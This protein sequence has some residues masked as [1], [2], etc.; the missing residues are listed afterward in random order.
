VL[1]AV[2]ILKDPKGRLIYLYSDTHIKMYCENVQ[3]FKTM[4]NTIK[5]MQKRFHFLVEAP[6]PVYDNIDDNPLSVIM[7]IHAY[8]NKNKFP[9]V[10][11]ENVELRHVSGI[12]E[13]ML[14]PDNNLDYYSKDQ[15]LKFE[16]GAKYHKDLTLMDVFNEFEETVRYLSTSHD[17]TT[18]SSF[19]QERVSEGLKWT[20]I[21]KGLITS[22]NI[23][24]KD[25]ITYQNSILD[26]AAKFHEKPLSEGQFPIDNC[27]KALWIALH[28]ASNPLIDIYLAQKV[29]EYK[30]DA[31]LVIVAGGKHIREVK[32]KVLLKL[33]YTLL[34]SNH[35][36]EDS[37]TSRR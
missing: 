33:G 20:E 21:V 37:L 11:A 24:Y 1:T 18:I 23:Q 2:D 26:I 30:G 22:F 16:T 3:Q 14:Y 28:N 10:T 12:A 34:H 15:L 17:N 25:N 31:S 8:I 36:S 27:R 19:I 29:I 35:Y 13:D 5:S 32:E 9:T 6:S 7:H 4:I